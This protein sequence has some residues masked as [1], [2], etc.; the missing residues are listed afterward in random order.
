MTNKEARAVC[1]LIHNLMRENSCSFYAF[2]SALGYELNMSAYG[3]DAV[4]FETNKNTQLE[5]IKF[6]RDLSIALEKDLPPEIAGSK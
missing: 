3:L 4:R 1:S 6:F 2:A 5:A